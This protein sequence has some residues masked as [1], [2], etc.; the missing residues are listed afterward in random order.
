MFYHLQYIHLFRPFLKYTPAASPLP[1]HVSPRRIC[2]AN[3]GAISKLMRLYKKT[4]NLRQICNIAV[5]MVHSACTI[6]MLNL[7]EKTARR[8]VIHGVRHLEEIAEDWL[9]A[10]RT[11]CILSVLAR[12]WNVEVPEEAALVLQRADEKYGAFISTS[13][14]PSPAGRSTVTASSPAL[15]AGAATL[16]QSQSPPPFASIQESNHQQQQQQH[17]QQPQQPYNNQQHHHSPLGQFNQLTPPPPPQAQL[18]QLPIDLAMGV[19]QQPSSSTS[20]AQ[21]NIMSPA[22]DSGNLPRA[23]SAAGHHPQHQHQR[24]VSSHHNPFQHQNQNSMH[25]QNMS[26]QSP[27][28]TGAGMSVEALAV[29]N[30]AAA[31]G[32]MSAAPTSQPQQQ[33]QQIS[34]FGGSHS[35]SRSFTTSTSGASNP[36]SRTARHTTRPN[37]MYAIDGQDWYIKDGVNW[38]QNFEAWGLGGGGNTGNSGDNNVFMFQGLRGGGGMNGL[39]GG[40]D[41]MGADGGGAGAFDALG[42]LGGILGGSLGSLDHLPGL[43]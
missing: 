33:Q 28:T 2:T 19:T 26:A 3:A 1:S 35:H 8:D 30:A 16:G 5:Y 34:G 23:F 40:G 14:V 31:W 37:S 27:V 12:K 29:V 15:G 22:I 6:H 43:D 41:E 7:P 36:T 21:S 17:H 20:V 39:G 42:S 13:D 24:H 32:G 25:H 9:C 11:L 10:R 18:S 4:Y 38:Q